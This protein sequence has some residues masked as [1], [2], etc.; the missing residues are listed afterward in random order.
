MN[1]CYYCGNT[2]NVNHV[3]HVH[4][5]GQGDVEYPCC[6][7]MVACINRVTRNYFKGNK[8]VTCGKIKTN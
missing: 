4:I 5:G 3:A 1:K 6:D 2:V 8:G 7:D